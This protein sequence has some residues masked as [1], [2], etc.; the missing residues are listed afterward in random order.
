MCVC[1]CVCCACARVYLCA[2]VRVY[3]HV[4][5]FVCALNIHPYTYVFTLLCP[6][7]LSCACTHVLYALTKELLYEGFRDRVGLPVTF[8][9]II[10]EG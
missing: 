6:I 8:S 2:C 10:V 7:C 5:V 4:R 1:V 3:M 9:L